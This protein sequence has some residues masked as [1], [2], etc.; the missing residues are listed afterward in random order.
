MQDDDM[1]QLYCHR[2][3]EIEHGDCECLPCCINRLIDEI[4]ILRTERGIAISTVGIRENEIQRLRAENERLIAEMSDIDTALKEAGEQHGCSRARS[5][6]WIV[7]NWQAA[8]SGL[9][10]S[11]AQVERYSREAWD[12]AGRLNDAEDEIKRLTGK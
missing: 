2:T 3:G 12:L 10:E 11:M 8:K 6:L 7:R 5:V 4:Q 1:T 9:K